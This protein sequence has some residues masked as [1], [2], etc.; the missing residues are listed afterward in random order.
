MRRCLVQRMKCRAAL[1]LAAC[2]L[3]LAS[4]CTPP[5]PQASEKKL[6]EKLA[7]FVLSRL[8]DTV[9]QRTYLDFSG[10]VQLL[11]Y[12]ISPSDIA[13]P[14]SN[15]SLTLYWQRTGTLDAGWGLFTHI[16]DER[17]RQIAQRDSSGPL[18]EPNAEGGQ[19]LGPSDWQIGKIY[20]DKLEFD[21]PRTQQKGGEQVPL[22]TETITIAVG[23]WKDTARL[24]VLGGSSDAHR[25]G[26]VTHLKTG[27][28][29]EALQ[30]EA[31]E[32]APGA[33]RTKDG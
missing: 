17:G 9:E 8:P 15:I 11:G 14:G 13:P 3:V 5:V 32:Q 28:K 31:A 30:E 22:Q 25:R 10:K 23:V 19:A 6:D 12:D 33:Q 16:L 21:V 29:R 1:C 26:F 20:V 4:G 18:R 7:P 24:D 2:Y 27:V